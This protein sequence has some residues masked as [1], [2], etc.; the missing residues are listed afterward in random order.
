MGLEIFC[1]RVTEF[2]LAGTDCRGSDAKSRSINEVIRARDRQ[3]A[4]LW[5]ETEFRARK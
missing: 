1:Q 3:G 2:H 4:V 5:V